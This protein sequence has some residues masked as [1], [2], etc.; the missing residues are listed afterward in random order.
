MGL[1]NTS[2]SAE[3]ILGNDRDTALAFQGT[4][5]NDNFRRVACNAEL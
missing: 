2:A 3:S 1:A 5:S 4:Y